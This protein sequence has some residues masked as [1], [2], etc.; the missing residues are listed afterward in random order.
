MAQVIV[1]ERDEALW[2]KL[3]E[4][5][6][7]DTVLEQDLL[8]AL[9]DPYDLSFEGD[10]GPP[11]LVVLKKVDDAVDL[12][13]PQEVLIAYLVDYVN[14]LIHLVLSVNDFEGRLLVNTR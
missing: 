5:R 7:V 1:S 9:V 6:G 2:S 12:L 14:I 10:L 13:L 8:R 4:D 3:F 11:A